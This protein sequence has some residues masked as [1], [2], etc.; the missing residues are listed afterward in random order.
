M[1][2]SAKLKGVNFFLLKVLFLLFASIQSFC[3]QRKDEEIP[4]LASQ[5]KSI[6]NLRG[7][8]KSNIGKWYQFNLFQRGQ[9]ILKIEVSTVRYEDKNYLCVAAFEKSFYIRLN[10]KHIEY[11]SFFWVLDTTRIEDVDYTDTS[12][13]TRIFENIFV[14]NVI[15]KTKPITWNDILLELKRCF[16]GTSINKSTHKDKFFIKY[17]YDYKLNKAQFYIG[18]FIDFEAETT[19]G[20]KTTPKDEYEFTELAFI[21]PFGPGECKDKNRNLECIYFEVPKILFNNIFKQ[22]LWD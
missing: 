18:G 1:T 6:N 8:A 2:L 16:I 11:S 3:Q 19:D 20:N 5:I 10:V 13:H 4:K 7:W 12:V 15:G 17:R 14:S 22:I 21:L 9:E